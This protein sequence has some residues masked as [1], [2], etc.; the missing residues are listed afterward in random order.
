MFFSKLNSSNSLQLPNPSIFSIRLWLKFAW[1][2]LTNYSNP[3]MPLSFKCD[4][5]IIS[6]ISLQFTSNNPRFLL[7]MILPHSLI[8]SSLISASSFSFL[9]S[10]LILLFQKI[11]QQQK[12]RSFITLNE[13]SNNIEALNFIVTLLSYCQDRRDAV[14]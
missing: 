8:I 10:K 6:I 4:K 2:K 11:Q 1:R 3:R 9:F 14:E 12:V 5:L 7:Y 13:Y